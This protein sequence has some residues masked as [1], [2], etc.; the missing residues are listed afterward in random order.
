[1][2]YRIDYK[3]RVSVSHCN[4][5]YYS[6]SWPVES[7]SPSWALIDSVAHYKN[8]HILHTMYQE[9][10][11]RPTIFYVKPL[12]VLPAGQKQTESYFLVRFIKNPEGSERE[13]DV[14]YKEVGEQW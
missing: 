5:S 13:Y 11:E 2:S 1:M 8:Q 3:F 9:F 7:A 14:E 6:R 4:N 12:E 10:G